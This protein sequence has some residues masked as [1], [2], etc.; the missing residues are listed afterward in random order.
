MAKIW[1]KLGY[2]INDCDNLHERF[3]Q[4]EFSHQEWCDMTCKKFQDKGMTSRIL[5]EIANE[6]SLIEGT[7]PTLKNYETI[8]FTYLLFQVQY[9]ML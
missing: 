9:E 6:I 1:L 2:T 4:K 8:T 7:I 3:S 5:Y